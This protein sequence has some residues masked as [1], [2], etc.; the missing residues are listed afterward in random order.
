MPF[1]KR[2]VCAGHALLIAHISD[3]SP[4]TAV[5]HPARS[6]ISLTPLSTFL[7]IR[8]PK[9]VRPATLVR[10]SRLVNARS[11][12][13]HAACNCVKFQALICFF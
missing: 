4:N 2:V 7:H 9:Q 13:G 11:V 8:E 6:G 5:T 12:A 3:V 1:L 10:I